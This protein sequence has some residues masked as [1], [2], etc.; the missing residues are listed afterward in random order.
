M[1]SKMWFYLN[2]SFKSGSR[3]PKSGWD[4]KIPKKGTSSISWNSACN[5]IKKKVKSEKEKK[6]TFKSNNYNK[7]ESSSVSSMF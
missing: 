2:L 3:D 5:N 6:N 7:K 1:L 4:S